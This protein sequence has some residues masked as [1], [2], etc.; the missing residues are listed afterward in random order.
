MNVVLNSR[1]LVGPRHMEAERL[2]R[3]WKPEELK[4]IQWS[5]SPS[6]LCVLSVSEVDTVGDSGGSYAR[7]VK[8]A[9]MRLASNLE[10]A[11]R[12]HLDIKLEP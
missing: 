12:R 6:D 2:T 10:E 11:L 7:M 5:Q 4:E 1:I 3:T 9:S 8:H